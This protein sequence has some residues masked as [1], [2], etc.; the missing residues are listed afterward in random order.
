[1]DVYD[2]AVTWLIHDWKNRKIHTNRIMSTVRFG[3]LSP[4]QLTQINL[5]P[6]LNKV[7]S[8]KDYNQILAFGTVKSMI[9]DGLAYS[10]LEESY[11]NQPEE[12]KKWVDKTGVKAPVCRTCLVNR[13]RG[14]PL[15][16]EKI[17][18]L[19]DASQ[20]KLKPN[21]NKVPERTSS[22]TL[23]DVIPKPGTPTIESPSDSFAGSE[24]P[25]N[26]TCNE[27][28]GRRSISNS[29]NKVA[30]RSRSRI[31][32][33]PSRVTSRNNYDNDK[34]GDLNNQ[35]PDILVNSNQGSQIVM[36]ELSK[37][38]LLS[39]SSNTLQLAG[40]G[41]ELQTLTDTIYDQFNVF[42]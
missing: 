32:K 37:P 17:S 5:C 22:Y 13:K 27:V 14:S 10:I 24:H 18:L 28:V 29:N 9:D 11:K 19:E 38:K 34:F 21:F 2:S 31:P 7:K 26:T 12:L 15:I 20:T 35:S 8:E 36:Q 25:S 1:M 6:E 23:L 30:T 16:L 33:P 39:N 41:M 3:L 40:D 4:L 42:K